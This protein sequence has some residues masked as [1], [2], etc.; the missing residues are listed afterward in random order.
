MTEDIVLLALDIPYQ[1]ELVTRGLHSTLAAKAG[2]VVTLFPASTTCPMTVKGRYL[3]YVAVAVVAIDLAAQALP[4][5]L[6]A[7]CVCYE[8][9]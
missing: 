5:T 4:V 6:P 8:E 9:N 1:G 2:I 7:P 3:M